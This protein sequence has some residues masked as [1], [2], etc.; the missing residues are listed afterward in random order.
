MKT[1]STIIVCAVL[2]LSAT[3]ISAQPAPFSTI[4]YVDINNIKAG[5][6][7]HGDMWWSPATQLAACEFPKSSGKNISFTGS[8]WMSGYDAGS[9]LHVA[10]QTYR[11]DGNDYWPGPLDNTGT[12]AYNTS[13]AWAKI[14]KVNRT[15]IDSF[16]AFT[17]HTSAN[18][19]P[20]ILQWPAKRNPYAAGNGGVALTI[21]SDMAPFV[22]VNHDGVY[23]ALQGDYPATKGDQ[24][25][26]WLY[27]D[28]GPV[29]TETNGTPLKVEIHAMAYAYS[30][31]TLID[32]AIYYEYNIFNKSANNYTNFRVGQFA[33]VELGAG[34]DDYIGFDSTHR[35]G[36]VYNSSSVDAV[37]GNMVPMAA[38]SLI[39]LPN[40][41]PATYVPAGSFMYYD[42]TV[43]PKRG[44]PATAGEHN[45]YLRSEWRDSTHLK[46]DFTFPGMPSVGYGTG[47]QD[48]NY[49]YSG[50]PSDNTQWS[51]CVCNN[52]P[53]DRRFIIASNDFTLNGGSSQKIV[54]ALLTT[55]LGAN[56]GCPNASFAN[57]KTVADTVWNIYQHPYP[58][59]GIAGAAVESDIHIYPDP[60]HDKLFISGG[61]DRANYRVYNM[62]GQAVAVPL[63]AA[64][65]I[66]QLDIAA[67][68]PGMYGIQYTSNGISTVM[69]FI[70][71]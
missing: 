40:D 24:T 66:V 57:I 56:N 11:Q 25:L 2:L 28:N 3:I 1:H 15:Q 63:S 54:I 18:T 51:E 68:V 7:V 10:A 70:K 35:M 5:V 26:W 9:Q 6:L 27:N 14:W 33:D 65:N 32:N 49:V 37:Y 47:Y 62:M 4:D 19:P 43:D 58:S 60:A 30:R 67:L 55:N 20:S 38:V 46:R 52:R 29:H 50:D 21:N 17:T 48:C 45:N 39:S 23:N 69:R 59:A 36:I 71:Y 22:D 8:L 64:E 16:L 44:N 12:I 61:Q 34:G 13:Q 53:D 42:N 31:G 41:G